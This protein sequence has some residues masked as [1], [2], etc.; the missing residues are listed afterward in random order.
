VTQDVYDG[1]Q[2]RLLLVLTNLWRAEQC[3]DQEPDRA[4]ELIREA[5]ACVNLRL[6]ELQS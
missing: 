5:L 4:R 1:V 2:Q 6:S 3:L